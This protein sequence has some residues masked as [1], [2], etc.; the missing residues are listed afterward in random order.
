MAAA[1]QVTG[2]DAGNHGVARLVGRDAVDRSEMLLYVHRQPF[3]YDAVLR[4]C[5]ESHGRRGRV[6]ERRRHDRHCGAVMH[7]QRRD[8]G[9]L[10]V[11]ARNDDDAAQQRLRL[12][13]RS[14][15]VPA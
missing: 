12:H 7:S 9:Q 5:P 3:P 8:I 14:L 11:V 10:G 2:E 15:H 1:G 4:I 13:V 6:V